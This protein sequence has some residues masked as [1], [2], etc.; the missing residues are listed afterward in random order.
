LYPIYSIHLSDQ[1][2]KISD[3]NVVSFFTLYLTS[4]SQ[5]HPWQMR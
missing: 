2:Q 1:P 4:P 5:H 3:V